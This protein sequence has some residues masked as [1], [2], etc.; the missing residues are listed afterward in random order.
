MYSL[1]NVY[2]N[3]LFVSLLFIICVVVIVT[4]VSSNSSKLIIIIIYNKLYL[5]YRHYFLN[6]ISCPF[7]LVLLVLF[8]PIILLIQLILI[9]YRT[10]LS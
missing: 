2:S 3:C 7:L 1:V 5:L 10:S 6:D 4:L 9:H 8:L